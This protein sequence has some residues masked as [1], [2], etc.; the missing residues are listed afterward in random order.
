MLAFD[1]EF[2]ATGSAEFRVVRID[3]AAEGT[4]NGEQRPSTPVAELV[5]VGISHSTFAAV[6]NFWFLGQL[7]H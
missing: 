7:F 2:V 6:Y 4:C 1:G 3:L 5:P